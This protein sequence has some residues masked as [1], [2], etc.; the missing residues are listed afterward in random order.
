MHLSTRKVD[1]EAQRFELES[2]IM[3]AMRTNSVLGKG[4]REVLKRFGHVIAAASEHIKIVD[5]Q[6]RGR[7]TWLDDRGGLVL[8][9]HTHSATRVEK[10]SLVLKS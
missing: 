8:A 7:C 1:D 9:E 5:I 6:T 3:M 10:R 2:T 4:V